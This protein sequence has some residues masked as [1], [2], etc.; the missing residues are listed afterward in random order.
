MKN[1][2]V[3]FVSLGLAASVFAAGAA[4]T[5]AIRTNAEEIEEEIV[6]IVDENEE[7][8]AL[9][10]LKEYLEGWKEEIQSWDAKEIFSPQNIISFISLLCSSGIGV[11]L[12][13][14]FAK[15]KTEKTITRDAIYNSLEK[16]LPEMSEKVLTEITTNVLAP[17]AAAVG[18]MEETMVIFSRCLALAQENTPEARLA[19][20]DEL[21][22]IKIKDESVIAKV[23]A[24]I[25]A[26]MEES[27]RQIEEKLALLESMQQL[28]QEAASNGE[29]V[30]VVS[31][32][33][34]TSI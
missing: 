9:D 14:V 5:T 30:E 17:L 12:V 25:K 19:I 6:E 1:K 24:A 34:G 8:T 28:Q 13:K 20:L 10:E 22:K 29:K 32:Y 2:K 33:D 23:D 11:A 27:K 7:K 18:S 31:E 26:A 16:A 3:L 4:T 21:S 15:Y